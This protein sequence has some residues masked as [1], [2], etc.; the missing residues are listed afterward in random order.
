MLHVLDEE[1]REDIF[2]KCPHVLK[3]PYLKTL[4]R[5]ELFDQ[6]NRELFEKVKEASYKKFC[7]KSPAAC[8]EYFSLELQ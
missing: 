4:D 2:H 8:P 5:L 3:C 6:T 7:D 1:I